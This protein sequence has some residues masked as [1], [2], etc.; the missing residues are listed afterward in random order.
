METSVYTNTNNFGDYQPFLIQQHGGHLEKQSDICRTGP[1]AS[2]D[3][4]TCTVTTNR[5]LQ[6]PY[7]G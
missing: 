2:L 3:E 5:V 6:T 7:T 1:P 4:N